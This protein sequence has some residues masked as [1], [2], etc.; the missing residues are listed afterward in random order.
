MPWRIALP[1]QVALNWVPDASGIFVAAGQEA[2]APPGSART[3]RK[4]RSVQP[5]LP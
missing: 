5:G 3:E 4:A 2:L 1:A